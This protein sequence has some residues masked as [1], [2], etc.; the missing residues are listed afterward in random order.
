ME[1]IPVEKAREIQKQALKE[2]EEKKFHV[3][4]LALKEDTD[5]RILETAKEGGNY[6]FT[7]E[8]KNFLPTV[9]LTTADE[10]LLKK[11][12]QNKMQ[13]VFGDAL[14]FKVDYL[15]AY[16]YMRISWEEGE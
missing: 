14:G 8:L 4:F 12:L 7:K 3:V 2:M 5:Q 9:F 11:Y 16:N 1:N 13:V 6:C 10:D 15:P